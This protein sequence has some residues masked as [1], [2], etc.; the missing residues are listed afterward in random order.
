MNLEISSFII[1]FCA[2]ALSIYSI[3]SQRKHNRLSFMPIPY[4]AFADYTDLIRVKI[5]NDGN[6]PLIIKNVTFT[7]INESLKRKDELYKLVPSPPPGLYWSDYSSGLKRTI[8]PDAEVIFL[9]L[10]PDSENDRD[11]EFRDKLRGYLSKLSISVEYTDVYGTKLG[12]YSRSFD[13][14]AR[15]NHT[16]PQ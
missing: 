1:A 2:F 4:V 5:R 16:R 14:F 6:G 11:V 9:C 7:E 10:R 12:P 15:H 3:C 8:R 13:W